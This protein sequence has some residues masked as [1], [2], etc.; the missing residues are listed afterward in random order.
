L[1][2]EAG[3]HNEIAIEPIDRRQAM[4]AIAR[5]PEALVWPAPKPVAQMP[6]L[7]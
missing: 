6:T 3:R 7:K 1:A 2:A 4:P 5:A